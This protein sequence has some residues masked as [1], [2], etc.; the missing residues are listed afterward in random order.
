MTLDVRDED[1]IVADHPAFHRAQGID[2][3]IVTNPRSGEHADD[4]DMPARR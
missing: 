1:D 2:R 4:A 3:I